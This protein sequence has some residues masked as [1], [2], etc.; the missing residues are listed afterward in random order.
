MHEECGVF[1]VFDPGEDVARLAYFSLYSLQHRGQE[2][3]GIATYSGK[4]IK[5]IKGLGLVSQVF[6]EEKLS[7]LDGD[8]AIAHNRYSTTGSD[9]VRNASPFV[10]NSDL[11]EFAVAHNGNITNALEL[12]EL[13]PES[14]SCTST[15]DSEILGHLIANA[16][17]ATFEARIL[18]IMEKVKGAYSMI[19]LTRN[20]LYAFRDSY[21]F[22][23]L[24]LA[25]INGGYTVASETCVF[26]TIGAKR[27][28]DVQ[29]GEIIKIQKNGIKSFHFPSHKKAFC[30]FE[31]IY[32]SRP[33]SII[34]GRSV[35]TARENLGKLLAKTCPKGIDM[36]IGVPD[37]GIPAAIGF[38]V[39]S[40]IP[41]REGMIKNRYIGR[42]FINPNQIQRLKTIELKLNALRSVISGKSIV[43]VD[44]SIVRGNT[45]QKIVRLLKEKGAKEVH[46]RISCP[47][48]MHPCF[49]GVDFPSYSELVANSNTT[50]KIKE[51]IGADSLEYISIGDLVKATGLPKDGFC[52][53]CFN[54]S[55]PY[56]LGKD[57]NSKLVLEKDK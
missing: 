29:P 40:R 18:K 26:G 28:R 30:I 36:I 55:Y 57:E 32:F 2:S 43:L 12:K 45:M 11:G 1:G 25:K 53:A 51:I 50:E 13:L 8:I 7:L 42:T 15:T 41:Y 27:I 6:N 3:A 39:A 35:Y 22:R 23:P 54:G 48:I 9:N 44:D 17:G 16:K 4:K 46:V 20:A 47:P 19:L 52:L 5:I 37:S 38:S 31:F 24:S 33:D 10:F 21:G 34:N 49:F 56:N 14:T